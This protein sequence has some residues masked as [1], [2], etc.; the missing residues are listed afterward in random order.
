[1]GDNRPWLLGRTVITKEM[2][3]HN[4]A[5]MHLENV[6][7]ERH[8]LSNNELTRDYIHLWPTRGICGYAV[9]VFV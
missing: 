8:L 5:L 3:D 2:L 9:L 7:L 1:M 4:Q 6:P